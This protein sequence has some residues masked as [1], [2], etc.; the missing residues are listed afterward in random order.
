LQ[1]NEKLKSTLVFAEG[2]LLGELAGEATPRSG[3]LVEC[4]PTSRSASPWLK[5]ALEGGYWN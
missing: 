3:S 2:V 4:P 5:G 1:K